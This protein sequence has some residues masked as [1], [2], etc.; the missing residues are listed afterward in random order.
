MNGQVFFSSMF[1]LLIDGYY[2]F[3]ISGYLQ[4]HDPAEGSMNGEILAYYIGH[5]GFWLALF[6]PF[7]IILILC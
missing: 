7:A 4:V 5:S 6:V 3:L 2:E 1:A